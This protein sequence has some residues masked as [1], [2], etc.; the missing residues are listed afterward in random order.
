MKKIF[1][2]IMALAAMTMSAQEVAYLLPK[3]ASYNA[4]TGELTGFVSEVENGVEQ[5][6]EWHAAEWFRATYVT[7]ENPKGQFITPVEFINEIVTNGL[8][9]KI[10]TLWIHADR[11]RDTEVEDWVNVA[12]ADYGWHEV[13][14][15]FSFV[16]ALGYFTVD[17]GNLLLT[18]QATHLAGDIQRVSYPE[19]NACG[20]IKNN[21]QWFVAT[22]F[23]GRDNST[24]PLYK[25]YA[26]NE[27]SSSLSQEGCKNLEMAWIKDEGKNTCTDHNCGWNADIVGDVAAWEADNDA[28]IIGTWGGRSDMAYAGIVDFEPNATYDGDGYVDNGYAGRVLTIGLAT[29]MWHT[30][31]GGWG[32]ENTRHM[33]S[34]ALEYL[35]P[36][37]IPTPSAVENVENV[38]NEKVL[39]VIENGQVF[40]IK[41]GVR[42]NTIGQEVR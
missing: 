20:Y 3:G 14:G 32:H 30:N 10:K 36:S 29:Y 34:C 4:E 24:H 2:S 9:T 12:K 8:D 13:V 11:V 27:E 39:K 7:G 25:R 42:Y 5:N 41:N 15:D 35:T 33:T 37:L 23:A 6:P 31:N 22:N 17:G 26:K 21:E 16:S 28:H 19:F 40:I 38:K 1:L 18:K